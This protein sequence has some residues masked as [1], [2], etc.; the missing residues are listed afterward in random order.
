MYDRDIRTDICVVFLAE[1]NGAPAVVGTTKLSEAGVANGLTLCRTHRGFA[2]PS[3]SATDLVVIRSAKE[4]NDV[5]YF[6]VSILSILEKM[7]SSVN[8][9][10]HSSVS[11]LRVGRL[12]DD[13]ARSCAPFSQRFVAACRCGSRIHSWQ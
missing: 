6:P 12:D 13:F 4:A 9:L 11:V 5:F 10:Q 1:S 8:T 7:R 3:T 2:L